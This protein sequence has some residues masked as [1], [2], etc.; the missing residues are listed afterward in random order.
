MSYRILNANND[1]MRVG[2][3]DP[4]NPGEIVEESQWETIEG[5]ELGLLLLQEYAIG[6]AIEECKGLHIVEMPDG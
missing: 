5:A 4:D 3:E 6:G 2:W 1:I